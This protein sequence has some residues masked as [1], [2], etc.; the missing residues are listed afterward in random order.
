MRP[1]AAGA[2]TAPNEPDGPTGGLVLGC[3]ADD[4]TGATDLGSTLVGEGM[5]VVQTVGVPAPGSVPAADALVVA[6]KSRTAPVADAVAQ[7]L[8]AFRVLRDAGARRFYFKY[9]STFDSRADGNIG[10]VADALLDA[11]GSTFTVVCPTFPETGRTVFQGHLFVGHELLSESPMADHP[12]TPM[13][14]SSVVRLMRRQTRRAVGLVPLPVVDEGAG[15]ISAALDAIR[16]DGGGYAVVDAVTDR[17]LRAIAAAGA[18]LPLL[19]G[20]SGLAR[21][22]PGA[23]RAEGLLGPRRAAVAFEPPVGAAAVLVGSVS[24]ATRRQVACFEA[25]ARAFE[26]D[27]LRLA[28]GVDDV[29]AIVASGVAGSGDRPILVRTALDPAAI[30]A[31]QHELGVER[32]GALVEEALAEAA[33]V[34]VATGVRRLVVAGGETSAAVVRALGVEALS[35]GPDIAPGVPWCVSLGE[36]RLALALKSG[37]FGAD[38][39][40]LDALAALPS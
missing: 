10:P 4:F 18:D 9:C 40:F 32:S 16:A 23:L 29:R 37:N 33:R 35:I 38:T 39:F 17:D 31:A 13:T 22:V 20:A 7:S 21:G 6:L 28:S 5:S 15:A 1:R 19:T 24:A 30:A 2:P 8:A 27:P 11:L 34:L 3:V 12:L 25:S 26:L 14:D 36:P